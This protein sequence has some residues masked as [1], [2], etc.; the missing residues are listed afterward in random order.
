MTVVCRIFAFSSSEN[1]LFR[2]SPFKKARTALVSH[3]TALKELW[4][5]M[6]STAYS[7]ITK[8]DPP[9]FARTSHSKG[10]LPSEAFAFC[11]YEPNTTTSPAFA[12]FNETTV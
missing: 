10:S 5:C 2:N 12:S 1:A 6:C 7:V 8:S 11:S 4:N 3:V 9:S